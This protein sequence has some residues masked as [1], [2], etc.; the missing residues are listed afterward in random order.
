MSDRESRYIST[1]HSNADMDDLTERL[2]RDLRAS[3][4]SIGSYKLYSDSWKAMT[5]TF[6]RLDAISSMEAALPSAKT[7]L[8]NVNYNSG[9]FIIL[10]FSIGCYRCRHV[11]YVSVQGVMVMARCG[12][13]RSNRCASF[14]RTGN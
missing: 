12:K 6:G 9:V 4:R 10:Y 8:G 3:I 14:S 5:A 2:S 13:V 7:G 1:K 11:I